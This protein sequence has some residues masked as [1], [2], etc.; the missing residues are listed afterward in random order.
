MVIILGFGTTEIKLQ[1]D[2][3]PITKILK[4]YYHSISLTVKF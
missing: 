3:N 4:A 2:K 1:E